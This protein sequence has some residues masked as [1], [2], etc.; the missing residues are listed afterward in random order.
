MTDAWKARMTIDPAYRVAD[1]DPRIYGSFIEHLGR[2]VYGGI[3][4]P[5]HPTADEDG[6][7][8]DVIDLVKELNVP[9]VRYPG[10][11]FVSGYRWEDGVGPVDERPV[12]LDLAWRSL[13]PNRVGLNEFARWAKKAD[14]QV[15][16]A[17][18]LGTRGIEDAKHLVE[19][20]NHPG[21]SYWS[22]LR[23]RHG[24]DK[25][26][27]IRVWCLGNE[28]DGPW[29]IG[30]KTADEYGRIAQEAAKVMKWV[31]PSIE[32][33]ACGSSHAKMPTFPDWERI[34]LEHAYDEIDYLSLHTYYGN[35]DGDLAN[36]LACSLDMD[37][38]IRTVVA[39]CDFV[40]AKKRSRKTIYLSFDEWNVWF[41]SNEADKQ[42][43]PWQVGP[44]LLEDVYTMEDAL[45]VGCMLI[46]LLKHADRVRIACLAQLVNVIA[47]IMT[48]NG[49]PSWRQTIFYPFQHASN[50][51]RGTVMHAPVESPKYDSKD[52][53]DVPYLEAVPV[54]NQEAGE[55][56]LLAVNRG[57]RP[58]PL[59]VDVRGFPG[60]RAEEH[61]V[62]AHPDVKAVNTKE[63]PNEIVPAKRA[64]EPVD[65]GRLAV[66][67]PALSWN[68]I[69]LSV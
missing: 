7:R 64:V 26:H 22:D 6:F 52:F 54:W 8:Q 50:L 48:E 59:E 5:G 60:A 55:L 36:F 68:V 33:V 9:I 42:V 69:R 58:L 40:R 20:C 30:H 16:M 39:T 10:G 62:L 21:G 51:A 27:G 41:H 18:N 38:F 31:D 4:D 37:A 15:M 57:E 13:E 67:L 2:A 45:V 56:V 66:L 53:T 61:L 11:N 1:L 3:Y 29:Q 23:R 19:Y 35:R 63:R 14:S 47:P 24:V 32:L 43:E 44:P 25:P 65:G 28:M 17:V 46:T 49:G 34:V 12:Q